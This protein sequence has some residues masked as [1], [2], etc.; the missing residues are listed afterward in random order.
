VTP[1]QKLRR[2]A[3]EAR[4]R[5]WI[6]RMYADPVPFLITGQA[7]SVANAQRPQGFAGSRQ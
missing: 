6:D 7:I 1:T 3:F 5:H 4:Y 2:I